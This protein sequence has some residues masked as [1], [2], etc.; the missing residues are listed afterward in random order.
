MSFRDME[1]ITTPAKNQKNSDTQ[2]KNN[3]MS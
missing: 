2:N 1:V 3:K